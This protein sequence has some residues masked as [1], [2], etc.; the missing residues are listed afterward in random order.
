MSYYLASKRWTP[1]PQLWCL[2][3]SSLPWV[4][5]SGPPGPGLIWQKRATSKLGRSHLKNLE[6]RYVDSMILK[7]YLQKIGMKLVVFVL[8][9]VFSCIGMKFNYRMWRNV[10][11]MSSTP[12]HP[13]KFSIMCLTIVPNRSL[14]GITYLYHAWGV[15]QVSYFNPP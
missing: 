7:L 9:I 3:M 6:L 1:R 10:F 15:S 14:I 5:M 4:R 11:D 12:W 8:T 2:R 13:I